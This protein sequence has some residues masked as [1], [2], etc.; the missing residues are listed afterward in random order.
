MAGDKSINWKT[1]ALACCIL[2]GLRL[3]IY[4]HMREFWNQF[5]HEVILQEALGQA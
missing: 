5:E 4:A 3:I 1:C 2:S